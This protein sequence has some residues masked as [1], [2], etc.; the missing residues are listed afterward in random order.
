LKAR[1]IITGILKKNPNNP[2]ALNFLGYSMLEKNE[3]LALAL[4]YIKKAVQLRP[5][6][7]Y[8]RD[9][10]GWYYFKVGQISKAFKEL[11]KAWELVKSD[12]IIAKHMATIYLK[13]KKY[14]MAFKFYQE[15]IKASKNEEQKKEV[16]ALIK[17]L[18]DR[19]PELSPKRLPASK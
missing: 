11:K 10:L 8:I 7:G 19:N 12:F 16:L 17:T 15:A 6:D 5:K 9:S 13:K 3:N 2:H 14:K 1:E 18:Q 4:K